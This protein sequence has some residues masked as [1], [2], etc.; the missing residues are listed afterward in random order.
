M[1]LVKETLLEKDL[2]KCKNCNHEFD[3]Y[4]Y[5]ESGMGYINCPKCNKPTTQK[6]SIVS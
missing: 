6:D 5:N 1:K 3:C 2:R 4:D